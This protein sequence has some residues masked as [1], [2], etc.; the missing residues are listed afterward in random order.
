MMT[1]T[2]PNAVRDRVPG[3]FSPA[4]IVL[5]RA[6]GRID[7]MGGI[8][9]YSGSLV[10][11]WPIA[12]ATQV[13]LQLQDDPA[14]RI[15]SVTAGSDERRFEIPLAE[16]LSLEY[17]SA[18]A[19]FAANHEQHWAAYI[20]GAFIVLLRERNYAFTHGARIL[21]SS[22]V[23]EGK[24]LSSSAAVEVA[25]MTAIVA[26]Y[27][28]KVSPVEIAFLCQR[29]ENAIA[30]A[31]C[32]V[33]DQ[34]TAA[35]GEADRLLALV[36]QPGELQ[37]TISLPDELTIWGVDSGIRHSVAG[38]DYG[39]VRTAAFMG[40]RIIQSGQKYLANISPE[41]FENEFAA[42]LPRQISGEEF[43]KRY[44]NIT[45]TVTSVDPQQTYPVFAAT[46]HPIYENARV[47]R[48]A[49]VLLNW[50]GLEQ[51]PFLGE[52]MYA[53]HNSYSACGLGSPGTDELVKLV[54]E[55]GPDHGLYGAKITGGGSGGTVAVL[56]RR[57]AQ[58]AVEEIAGIYAQ[59]T[60]YRP[61][62]ISGSSPGA[63]KFGTLKL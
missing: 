3:F 45:D 22:D 25:T 19:R 24:G 36:C 21:I 15:C 28:I 32:G 26:A 40:H 47:N 52:L 38:A 51:A 35:C 33:M 42:H 6:P 5:S 37:G 18:R 7:L 56:G 43:L 58:S 27:G 44:Q 55:A 59:R 1:E 54:R 48:F 17:E 12:A 49:Q 8:A 46:S 20:A 39:I 53:S 23:P 57:A 11:Q 2:P 4:E 61:M 50:T 29:V 63:A 41:Q 16:L 14:I 13:A 30:G 60:G 10:L 31:P 62:I 9:D 34:M